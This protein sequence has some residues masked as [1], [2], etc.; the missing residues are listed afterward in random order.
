MKNIAYVGRVL[1]FS[2]LGWGKSNGYLQQDKI[3]AR[4]TSATA[5]WWLVFKQPI[6]T[7]A[8]VNALPGNIMFQ[9]GDSIAIQ[10][11]TTIKLHRTDSCESEPQ[12]YV[13]TSNHLPT[14]SDRSHRHAFLFLFYSC[15]TR[16]RTGKRVAQTCHPPLN[17]LMDP[18]IRRVRVLSS[19]T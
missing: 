17:P 7:L 4:T 1:R 19:S 2:F 10:F 13:P 3:E 14:G 12:I 11:H 5:I 18:P 6:C 9:H 8:Y 16:P 15:N